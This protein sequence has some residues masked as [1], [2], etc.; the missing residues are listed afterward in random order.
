MTVY[1]K[2]LFWGGPTNHPNV[3]IAEC[4]IGS[5]CAAMKAKYK[6]EI[7]RLQKPKQ[8]FSDGCA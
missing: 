2:H 3:H 8:G 5:G 1:K 4:K 6:N 7:F